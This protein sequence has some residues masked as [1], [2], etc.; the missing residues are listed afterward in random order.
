MNNGSLYC[1][2]LCFIKN[3][4]AFFPCIEKQM[5]LH[6]VLIFLHFRTTVFNNDF[7]FVFLPIVKSIASVAEFKKKTI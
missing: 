1:N 5:L 6:N 2:K 7:K 4:F 3:N